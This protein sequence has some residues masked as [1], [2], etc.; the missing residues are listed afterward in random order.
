MVLRRGSLHIC[1]QQKE[2]FSSRLIRNL[3]IVPVRKLF[4]DLN[5]MPRDLSLS[6]HASPPS[7]VF[8][9]SV[10][11]LPEW[12]D[13]S[14]L[15]AEGQLRGTQS[16]CSHASPVPEGTTE[17]GGQGPKPC[18]TPWAGPTRTLGYYLTV[19]RKKMWSL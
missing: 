4:T 8:R 9:N 2:P 13:K 6:T 1:R 16:S 19:P 5:E 3:K 18:G 10:I 7:L 14:A 15:L 12:K 17:A 11:N